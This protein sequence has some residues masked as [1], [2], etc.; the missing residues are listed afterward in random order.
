[1]QYQIIVQL[2]E[3]KY[4]NTLY[5]IPSLLPERSPSNCWGSLARPSNTGHIKDS[6]GDTK[7][8]QKKKKGDNDITA[9]ETSLPLYD[10]EYFREYHLRFTPYGLSNLITTL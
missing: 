9:A 3:Y 2:P 1:M 6:V 8:K 7:K 5:L 4:K 10:T